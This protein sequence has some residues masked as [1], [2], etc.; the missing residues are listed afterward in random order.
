MVLLLDFAMGGKRSDSQGFETTR[1]G[2]GPGTFS[3]GRD[4]F[5][6]DLFILHPFEGSGGAEESEEG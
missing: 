6:S 1:A 4:P 3:E 2:E 5:G